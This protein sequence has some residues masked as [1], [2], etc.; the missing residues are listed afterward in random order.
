VSKKLIYVKY[1]TSYGPNHECISSETP[2]FKPRREFAMSC[3]LLN[4]KKAPKKNMNK[5]KT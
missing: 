1:A 2:T 5:N 3:T 4:N